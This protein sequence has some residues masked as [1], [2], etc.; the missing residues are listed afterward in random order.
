MHGAHRKRPHGR[1][2]PEPGP[3]WFQQ[4]RRR[5]RH[6]RGF[7]VTLARACGCVSVPAY[8]AEGSMLAAP[9]RLRSRRWSVTPRCGP[10]RR[11]RA[12]SHRHPAR[13]QPRT[14]HGA[15]G[16]LNADVKPHGDDVGHL[17]RVA[18]VRSARNREPPRVRAC[19]S[20]TRGASRPPP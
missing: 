1:L 20:W 11:V 10:G 13:A 19:T 5:R 16:E 4:M 12:P 15:T 14:Y 3:G 6:R 17:G 7:A 2:Q 8:A 18:R 9:E